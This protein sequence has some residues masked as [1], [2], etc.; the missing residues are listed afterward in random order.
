MWPHEAVTIPCAG[1]PPRSRHLR[2]TGG[3]WRRAKRPP[4]GFAACCTKRRSAG[5][6][7]PRQANY[8]R[9]HH[10]GLSEGSQRESSQE[11][12]RRSRFFGT[13]RRSTER[14]PCSTASCSTAAWQRPD[15]VLEWSE[16]ARM[17]KRSGSARARTGAIRVQRR[18]GNNGGTR[19]AQ[20]D[21]TVEPRRS[22]SGSTRVSRAAI[23]PS[24]QARLRRRWK[25]VL[26][27]SGGL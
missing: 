1:C 12:R 23:A 25:H 21:V 3:R 9:S 27:G 13:G 15:G 4:M 16:L 7:P 14:Q 22:M 2:A 20:A 8:M 10:E 19:V 24:R 6:A 11:A 18:G 26:S 17:R 5:A